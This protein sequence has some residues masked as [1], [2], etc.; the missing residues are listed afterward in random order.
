MTPLPF[1]S[2]VAYGFDYLCA[3]ISNCNSYIAFLE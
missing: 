2:D 1:A 3:K